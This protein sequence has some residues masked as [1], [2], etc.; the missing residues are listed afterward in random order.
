[1]ALVVLRKKSIFGGKID[2]SNSEMLRCVDFWGTI[3]D[4][5]IFQMSWLSWIFISVVLVYLNPVEGNVQVKKQFL[6]L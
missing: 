2:I 3:Y 6:I 5:L 1:M 4:S